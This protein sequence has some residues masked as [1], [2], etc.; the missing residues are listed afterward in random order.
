MIIFLIS[1]IISAGTFIVIMSLRDCIKTVKKDRARY[2]YMLNEE[3]R[4][5]TIKNY[6]VSS[7]YSTQFKEYILFKD[8]PSLPVEQFIRFYS[9]D[10]SKWEMTNGCA[11]RKDDHSVGIFFQPYS[12]Y[13][14]YEKF[15]IA[16][17]KE[18]ELIEKEKAERLQ[19]IKKNED[20][21]AILQLVQKD[22]D[23]TYEKAKQ[24]LE[25]ATET[26]NKIMDNMKGQRYDY[27]R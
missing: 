11:Y 15:R 20:L 10:P 6:G 23:E 24:E 12:N 1:T 21:E 2:S 27:R 22:I 17:E 3:S 26:T 14:A 4:A 13:K 7:R 9:V 5:Y 8:L 19:T 16:T 25:K 18:Y